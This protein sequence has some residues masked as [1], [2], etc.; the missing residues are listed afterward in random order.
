M[1]NNDPCWI[2][3]AHTGVLVKKSQIGLFGSKLYD[4]KIT[5]SSNTAVGLSKRFQTSLTPPD[6][7]HPLLKAFTN[8]ALHCSDIDEVRRVLNDDYPEVDIDEM[9]HFLQGA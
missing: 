2:G 9:G 5:V 3:V 1:D 8:A 7:Q 4:E 6:M